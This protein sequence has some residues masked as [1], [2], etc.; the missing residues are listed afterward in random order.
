MVGG[1]GGGDRDQ[2]S[3]NQRWVLGNELKVVTKQHRLGVGIQAGVHLTCLG[4]FYIEDVTSKQVIYPMALVH[5]RAH[6]QY[7][8]SVWGQAKVLPHAPCP[9]GHFHF[10]PFTIPTEPSSPG[11]GEPRISKLGSWRGDTSN[12]KPHE[13]SHARRLLGLGLNDLHFSSP[14]LASNCMWADLARNGLNDQLEGKKEFLSLKFKGP[15]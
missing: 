9:S 15:C 12:H 7:Y 2:N 5:L 8:P 3:S 11:Q 10:S 14:E 13:S 4:K 6:V 1:G